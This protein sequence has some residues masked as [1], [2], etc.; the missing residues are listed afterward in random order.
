MVPKLMIQC[1]LKNKI[2]IHIQ[3]ILKTLNFPPVI[4]NINGLWLNER[5]LTLEI[6][7]KNVNMVKIDR[8]SGGGKSFSN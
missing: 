2:F 5:F 4:N 8:S 3:I 7:L 6:L 1:K